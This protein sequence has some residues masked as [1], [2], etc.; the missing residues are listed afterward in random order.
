MLHII[1]VIIDFLLNIFC[2]KNVLMYRIYKIYYLLFQNYNIELI[3]NNF[4][5]S[6]KY[7]K[8]YKIL[9]FNLPTV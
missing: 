9:H 1:F 7:W 2:L 8:N 5:K 6:I 3:K 4:S